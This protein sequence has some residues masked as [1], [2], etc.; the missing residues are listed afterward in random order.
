MMKMNDKFRREDTIVE[1]RLKTL[2]KWN[3]T[4]EKK[5]EKK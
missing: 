3:K 5:S 2:E 1:G 4:T